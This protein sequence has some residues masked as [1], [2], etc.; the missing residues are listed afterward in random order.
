MV[1]D[2]GRKITLARTVYCAWSG[3][4]MKLEPATRRESSRASQVKDHL[5]N[6]NNF[7]GTYIY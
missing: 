5:Q 4:E 6:N 3:I 2:K 1:V 7:T